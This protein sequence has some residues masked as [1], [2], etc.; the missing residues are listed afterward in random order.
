MD[1]YKKVDKLLSRE[2]YARVIID[3]I[4]VLTGAKN[5]IKKYSPVL[6][7]ENNFEP[8]SNELNN[9]I[10]D[11]DYVSV[12]EHPWIHIKNKEEML[13]RENYARVI[14]DEII[15]EGIKLSWKTLAEKKEKDTGTS[16]VKQK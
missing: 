16:Q 8:L 5:T 15:R 2:N 4:R 3:E 11:Y 13:S 9:L 7:I 12:S 1:T 6:F 14:I 10:R